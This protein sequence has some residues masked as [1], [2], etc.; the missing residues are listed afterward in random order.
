[1]FFTYPKTKPYYKYKVNADN[2]YIDGMK[3]EVW[4][5]LFYFIL[6]DFSIKAITYSLN[7]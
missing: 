6:L 7:G 3:F 2:C 1:M 5:R 4:R